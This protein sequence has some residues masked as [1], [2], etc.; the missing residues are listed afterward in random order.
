MGADRDRAL[1]AVRLSL[2]RWT[3]TTDIDEATD[4]LAPRA[5]AATGGHQDQAAVIP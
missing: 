3:T 4:L 2:S 5:E 1:G